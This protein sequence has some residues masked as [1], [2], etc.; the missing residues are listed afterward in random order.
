VLLH[1]QLQNGARDIYWQAS[2][3]NRDITIS[4]RKGVERER[5]SDQFSNWPRLCCYGWLTH[6]VHKTTTLT[7]VETNGPLSIYF[8]ALCAD[9]VVTELVDDENVATENV[10]VKNVSAEKVEQ[11]C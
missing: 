10:A 8:S 4:V 1:G 2:V 11:C 9:N 5:G 3:L 7:Q 6:S